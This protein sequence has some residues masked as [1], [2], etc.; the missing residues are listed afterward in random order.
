M[1]HVSVVRFA[2]RLGDVPDPYRGPALDFLGRGEVLLVAIGGERDPFVGGEARPVPSGYATD[3]ALVWPLSL[4]HL[5]AHYETLEVPAELC[6]YLD[7]GPTRPADLDEGRSE[8]LREYV[9]REELRR[10]E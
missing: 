10:C 1:R 4:P 6:A 8:E 3:G 9:L 5:L 7:A 2:P